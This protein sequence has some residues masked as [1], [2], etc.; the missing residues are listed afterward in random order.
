[1]CIKF[2][3]GFGLLCE[4]LFVKRWGVGSGVDME[5]GTGSGL[6][7]LLLLLLLL[8]LMMLMLLLLLLWW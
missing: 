3:R 1:M 8:M 5:G 2:K 6:L 4:A 7:L